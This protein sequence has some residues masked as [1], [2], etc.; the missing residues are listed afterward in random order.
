MVRTNF[1]P[2]FR[3]KIGQKQ[4]HA[5]QQKRRRGPFHLLAGLM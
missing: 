4:T 2:D 5:L 1:N 3:N